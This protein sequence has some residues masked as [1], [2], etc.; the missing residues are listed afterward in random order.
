MLLRQRVGS[1]LDGEQGKSEAVMLEERKD[2]AFLD[3]GL[4][5]SGGDGARVHVETTGSYREIHG[6]RRQRK[7]KACSAYFRP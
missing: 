1:Y 6:R 4:F 3:P 5:R 2:G 7:R